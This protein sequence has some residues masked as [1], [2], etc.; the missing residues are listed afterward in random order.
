MCGGYIE[1]SVLPDG[2]EISYFHEEGL[3]VRNQIRGLLQDASKLNSSD[4]DGMVTRFFK[5]ERFG[6]L[7]DFLTPHHTPNPS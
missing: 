7:V 1:R 3:A 4:S 2:G 5:S 6:T